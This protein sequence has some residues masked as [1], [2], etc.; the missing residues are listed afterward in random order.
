MSMWNKKP[1]ECLIA[2][3]IWKCKDD[4]T[5]WEITICAYFYALTS[6]GG[7]EDVA[8]PDTTASVLSTKFVSKM[9]I[10]C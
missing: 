4:V 6:T 9:S 7:Y 3:G 5:Y 1:I 10:S 8:N 2:E